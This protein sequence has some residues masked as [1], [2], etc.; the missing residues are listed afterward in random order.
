MMNTEKLHCISE[1]SERKNQKGKKKWKWKKTR[2]IGRRDIWEENC[3]TQRCALENLN[4]PA[5]NENENAIEIYPEN[6]TAPWS[7]PPHHRND[8]DD[9]AADDSFSLK[10]KKNCQT[11]FF[12]VFSQPCNLNTFFSLLP[13][14]IHA[15]YLHTHTHND[16]NHRCYCCCCSLG[17]ISRFQFS[18]S[19]LYTLPRD[20]TI[21]SS[22]NLQTP[23]FF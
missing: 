9:D 22:S 18:T 20:S 2:I 15:K 3:F 19:N 12:S 16:F 13:K 23:T 6:C 11:D 8:D 5:G 4:H 17:N 1:K 14:H 7:L 10:K 21:L